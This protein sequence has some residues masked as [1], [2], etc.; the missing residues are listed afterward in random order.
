MCKVSQV[1]CEDTTQKT[2]SL[3]PSSFSSL[4]FFIL[5]SSSHHL[6]FLTFEMGIASSHQFTSLWS[7]LCLCCFHL[8]SSIKGETGKSRSRALSCQRACWYRPVA[9]SES[10]SDGAQGALCYKH[11]LHA[12]SPPIHQKLAS[13][14]K[15]KC[16]VSCCWQ[17]PGGGDV[18]DIIVSIHS[19]P[20][21]CYPLS[22]SSSCGVTIP[23][24]RV[25]GAPASPPVEFL[26]STIPPCAR[27]M[28]ETAPHTPL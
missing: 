6:S 26:N 23:P 16:T 12:D 17:P 18:N 19:L 14:Y 27:I 13:F 24:E 8:Y 25:A 5:H 21:F 11:R 1:P 15:L 28:N 2:S 22:L 9:M 20:I 4:P 7:L 10:L 3:P